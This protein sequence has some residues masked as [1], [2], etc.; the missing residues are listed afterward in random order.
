MLLSSIATVQGID[1]D[2]LAQQKGKL[3][4]QQQLQFAFQKSSSFLDEN[5]FMHVYGELKNL[6]NKAMKN[7]IVTATFYD[8]NGKLLNQFR[9]SSELRTLNPGD[10]SPFEI[11]YI[12]TK[13][14]NDVKNYTLSATGQQTEMKAR[15]LHITSN[16]SKLDLTGVYYIKGRVVNEGSKDAT[17]SMII[18]TL[19]N[20][21][22]KVVVVGRGQTE[23]VNISSHSEAAFDFPVTEALQTY[24][25]KSYS[26]LA[27][28]D[29]Y[30]VV[31][32]FSQSTTTGL[33]FLM[34][35]IAVIL[36]KTTKLVITK[37]TTN[38]HG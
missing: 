16:S 29:Q 32:E 9:R 24:K 27:D 23:P 38:S 17:N 19:Y 28:S 6:S 1:D 36:N 4:H 35:T 8:S 14:V 13:T 31:P 15:A 25:V 7:V 30:V 10:V 34:I 20:K 5:N 2:V 18:A 3:N 11:L 37:S 22:G 12:D 26:L 21:D 33:L